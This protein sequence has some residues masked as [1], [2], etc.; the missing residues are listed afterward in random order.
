MTDSGTAIPPW[1]GIYIPPAPV[2]QEKTGQGAPVP[3]SVPVPV[4]MD[5]TGAGVT[6]PVVNSALGIGNGNGVTGATAVPTLKEPD[7][8]DEE[9]RRRNEER[10]QAIEA[11]RM[12]RYCHGARK[13]VGYHFPTNYWMVPAGKNPVDDTRC[14]YC[15]TLV[16]FKGTHYVNKGRFAPVAQ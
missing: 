9:D 13:T 5:D 4:P 11:A 7:I 2:G 14:G 10:D 3:V 1:L 8:V 12:R 16:D 15:Q 6:A